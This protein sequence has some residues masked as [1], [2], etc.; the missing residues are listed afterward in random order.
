[1]HPKPA[2]LI[3]ASAVGIYPEGGPFTESQTLPDE[4]FLG[5]LCKKWEQEAG[6]VDESTRLVI[7]RIG[8]VLD[9]KGGAL[10]KMLPAFKLGVGGKIA[11][12]KQGFSWIHIADLVKAFD[13]VINNN[14]AN[15]VVNLTA[16]EPLSNAEFTKILARVMKRPA[17]FPV[18]AFILKLLYGEAAITLTTGQLVLPEKL[19]SMGFSFR[20]PSL[21]PA[22]NDLLRP[23]S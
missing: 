18:P 20:F 21:E 14:N 15:G 13:F 2:L 1:M 19:I 11:S 3:S 16:P 8:I 7:F 6:N 22:L 17:L 10:P 4:G 5:A 23:Q 9:T 12:G